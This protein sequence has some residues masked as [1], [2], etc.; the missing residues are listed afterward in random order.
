M[1]AKT[2]RTSGDCNG[3]CCHWHIL[4][5]FCLKFQ[6]ISVFGIDFI[7]FSFCRLFKHD[8]IAGT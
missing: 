2:W 5:Y 3:I 1:S 6:I 8:I 7:W 4:L